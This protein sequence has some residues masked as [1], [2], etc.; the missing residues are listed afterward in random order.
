MPAKA[1]KVL[2]YLLEMKVTK[3]TDALR[4]NAQCIR[5]KETR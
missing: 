5:A 3:A 4:M 2:R 1:A